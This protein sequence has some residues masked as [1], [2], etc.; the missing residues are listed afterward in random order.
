[1]Q[2][3]IDRRDSTMQSSST[4]IASEPASASSAPTQAR[5]DAPASRALGGLLTGPIVPTLL[6]LAAPT[7]VVLVVQTFV[8]VIETYFVGFLGK[9]ALA[10]VALVFPVLMLMTM[11]SNGALGGGAASAVARALGSGRRRDAD[12]LVLHAVMLAMLFGLAFTIGVLGGGRVLYQALGGSGEAI[13]AALQYSSFVFGGAVL[14]WVVNLLAASLRGA[15]DV[16]TPAL[17]IFAGALIVVPLSPALIFGF[18]PIPRLGIAGAGAAV[19]FYYVLASVALIAYMRSSRSP[20][21]L[22]WTRPEWRLF[23]DILGV[24]GISAIGTLQINVTVAVVT[25][26]VGPF[27]TDALAGYGM[28]SRLDYLLIPLLFSLGT[29]ATTMVGTNIGARQIARAR[30]IAWTAALVGAAVTETIGV[31]AALFPHVWISIFSADPNVIAA[32][33]SY[34]RVVAPFY[35]FVGLGMLLYFAGQGARHVTWPVLAGTLRLV[36]VAAGGWVAIRIFQA[37]LTWLFAAVAA[38]SLTFGAL[39]ALAMRLQSWGATAETP[40]R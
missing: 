12:A 29:A 11:M 9:D 13:E 30:R 37:D 20:V 15:G 27:G 2:E 10:G 25:A 18:G 3:R 39:T 31:L 8:S 17:V 6:R 1:M 36:I 38:A 26:L 24:G 28:A 33:S 35:G 5:S 34:L 23:K 4:A 19:I 7:V 14:T 32:G 21:R 16:R 22:I 40:R